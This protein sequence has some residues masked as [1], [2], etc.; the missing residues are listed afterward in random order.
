VSHC[1]LHPFRGFEGCFFRPFSGLIWSPLG[2]GLNSSKFWD[3]TPS[4]MVKIN[5]RF[6]GQYHFQWTSFTKSLLSNCSPP[7]W[8]SGQNS[9]LQIRRSRALFP[10]LQDFLRSSGYESKPGKKPGCSRCQHGLFFGSEDGGYV[11]PKLQLTFIRL[12]WQIRLHN[13]EY[14]PL[15]NPSSAKPFPAKHQSCQ[16]QQ[17]YKSLARRIVISIRRISQLLLSLS[18]P[19][20]EMPNVLWTP[21]NT[22]K[23]AG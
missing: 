14:T 21:V 19:S 11:S 20:L 4:S 5:R 18:H 22:A 6:G 23:A 7:L 2:G 8:S 17:S 10:A 13:D 3:T 16:W 15:N 12:S 9:W 1:V